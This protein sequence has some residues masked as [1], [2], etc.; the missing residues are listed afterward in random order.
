MDNK[1][2]INRN[3][4]SNW[5]KKILSWYKT[6]KRDLPWRKK[7]N[8][9]FYKIW[10]SEVML[11]QTRV[12]TVIPY[13]EKFLK[14]WPDLNSFYKA[15]LDDILLQWQGLGYY[16]RAKNLYLGKEFLR[17]NKFQL[18]KPY[19]KKVP[20]IG[21]YISSAIPAILKDEP[22]VVLD[23][24]IKRIIKRCFDLDENEKGSKKKI[25]EIASQL[26][27]KRNN[28][29]YCQSLMDLANIVCKIK[30][31]ECKICPV[32]DEC[33]TNGNHSEKKLIGKTNLKKRK[34]GVTFLLEFNKEYLIEHTKKKL[35]E[36]LF[37]FP[38]TD[39]IEI[40]SDLS[41]ETICEKLI[42]EWKKKN[43]INTNHET[44]GFIKHSF[45]HFHLKLFIVNIKLNKKIEFKEMN[46]IKTKDFEKKPV[47][48]LVRKIKQVA[49]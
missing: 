19:L 39:L 12:K 24:N 26:T 49:L 10:I 25:L 40:V 28:R 21:D 27:P 34:I 35:L 1:Y 23:G 16:Q 15:K 33:K 31:P 14:K 45:S 4:E 42:F 37:T 30:S 9:N 7:E 6:N 44:I 2:H 43:H 36:G 48:K 46:W 47:S 38:M 5:L 41:E 3:F 20:G 32:R 13:Y 22:C 18:D 11:Q 17:K 8:Q 29:D